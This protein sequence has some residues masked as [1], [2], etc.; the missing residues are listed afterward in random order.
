MQGW[1]VS[2]DFNDWLVLLDHRHE[3]RDGE[4]KRAVME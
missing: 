1:A 3:G 4:R 2:I